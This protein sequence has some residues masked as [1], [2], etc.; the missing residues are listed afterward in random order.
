MSESSSIQCPHCASPVEI[1]EQDEMVLCLGCHQQINLT[2]HLCP[3]CHHYHAEK[4]AVCGE[5]GQTI[6]RVCRHCQA[7]NWA[8]NE[9]CQGCGRPLDI[10][11]LMVSHSDKATPDRLDR[12]MKEAQRYKK[13]EE[14]ASRK[15]MAEFQAIEDE[16]QAE[17]QM[18]LQEKRRQERAMLVFAGGAIAFFFILI[19][20]YA[21]LS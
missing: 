21:I 9:F 7:I 4:T 10:F 20:A 19:L 8:G 2:N 14:E 18:R 5:C 13:T 11:E 6:N 1:F 12:Q 17:L 15:R 3:G 16:R